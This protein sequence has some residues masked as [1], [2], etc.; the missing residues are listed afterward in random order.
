MS[1]LD[2]GSQLV[3]VGLTKMIAQHLLVQYDAIK[4]CWQCVDELQS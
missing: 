3:S 2:E 4:A 1:G